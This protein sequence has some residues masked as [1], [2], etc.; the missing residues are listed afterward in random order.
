MTDW[1]FPFD[2]KMEKTNRSFAFLY[3]MD[4][5]VCICL[6]YSLYISALPVYICLC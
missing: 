1:T 2:M 4:D 5:I 3:Y 6:R